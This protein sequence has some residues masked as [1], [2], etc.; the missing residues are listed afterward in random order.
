M[1][2]DFTLCIGTVGGGL[3]CS[4]DGGQTWNRIRQP[5]P[6]ENRNLGADVRH[7]TLQSPFN[8]SIFVLHGKKAGQTPVDADGPFAD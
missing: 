5:I 1:S 6:S 8:P 3:S 7:V 2:Q 4:P